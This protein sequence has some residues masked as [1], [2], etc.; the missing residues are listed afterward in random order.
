[1]ERLLDRRG[2]SE[3]PATRRPAIGFC[4]DVAPG[5][6][7][8]VARDDEAGHRATALRAGGRAYGPDYYGAFILDPA[9]NSVEAVNNGPR[10]QP[11]VIDHLWLRTSSLERCEPVLRDRLPDRRPHGRALRGTHPD[12]GLGRHVLT[13]RRTTHREP[14][15]RLRSL[16]TRSRRRFP[17]SWHRGRLPL[18]RCPRR[19]SPNT[20]AATTARSSRIRTGTTSRPSTTTGG[21]LGPTR[22][23]RPRSSAGA[24]ERCA[25]GP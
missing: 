19:A 22:P 21:T 11:G 12:P 15:S 9:G 7:R 4:A 10:R 18:Q 24:R 23:S 20:I 25:T 14:P 8:L 6:R 3:R 2:N 16:R 5:R 17:P 13:R 1:M